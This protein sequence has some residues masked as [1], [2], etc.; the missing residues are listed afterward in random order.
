MTLLKRRACAAAL[1]LA[2]LLLA[3]TVAASGAGRSLQFFFFPFGV[4]GKGGKTTTGAPAV[5]GS[6]QASSFG[7]TVTK[8]GCDFPKSPVAPVTAAGATTWRAELSGANNIAPGT[9]GQKAPAKTAA[10]GTLVLVVDEAGKQGSWT[11]E[12]CNVA[13]G[14]HG[15]TLPCGES[16]CGSCRNVSLLLCTAGTGAAAGAAVMLVG[17]VQKPHCR[18]CAALFRATSANVHF[19]MVEDVVLW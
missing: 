9:T 10:S 12:L 19:R 14:L 15:V 5:A 4:F 18:I 7:V 11:L 1:L 6:S 13:D 3:D 2:T 8:G 16:S 17:G